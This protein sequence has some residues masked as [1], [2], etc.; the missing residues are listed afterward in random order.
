M[1][2]LKHPLAEVFGFK[3][4]NHSTIAKKHRKE[5][6]CPHKGKAEHCTKSS[7][8]SPIAVCS[9]Y[10]G[11]TTTVI[12]PVRFEEEGKIFKDA[13]DFFFPGSSSWKVL[14]EIRLKER[15]GE[16]AGNIDFVLVTQDEDGKV[17]DFGAL[18]VQAVYVSGNISNP[19][20]HYM[21]HPEGRDNMDWTQE[22]NYPRPDYL[23]SSR[24]RLIPQLIYKGRILQDWGKKTAVAVDEPFFQTMPDL[25]EVSPLEADI[26]WLVYKLMPT[27]D[28]KAFELTLTKKVYTKFEDALTRIANPEIGEIEDFLKVVRKKLEGKADLGKFIHALQFKLDCKSALNE[29]ICDLQR[30]LDAQIKPKKSDFRRFPDLDL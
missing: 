17:A 26:V 24:K 13:A 19:F 20:E 6:L 7:V 3:T 27:S 29:F 1:T 21:K 12:C 11:D 15:N 10:A 2:K 8:E 23:S 14:P 30:A 16:S 28:S 5:K 4:D 25:P 18:E 9:I 22:K